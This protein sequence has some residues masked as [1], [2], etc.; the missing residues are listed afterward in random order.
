MLFLPKTCIPH[1]K[2]D[3]SVREMT[4]SVRIVQEQNAILEINKIA[5][6]NSLHNFKFTKEGLRVWRAFNV[7]PK[8]FIPRNKIVIC[9]QKKTDLEEEISQSSSVTCICR[10]KQSDGDGDSNSGSPCCA[11]HV[12]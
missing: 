9:P 3:V 5:N 12:I 10:R 11:N 4:A 7:G 1:Q 8:M 2:R 6:F